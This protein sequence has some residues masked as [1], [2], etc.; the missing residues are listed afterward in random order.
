MKYSKKSKSP[1]KGKAVKKASKPKTTR[2]VY[3]KRGK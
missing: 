2:G 3:S 1:S